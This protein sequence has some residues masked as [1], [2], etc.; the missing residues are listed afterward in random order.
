M[1]MISSIRVNFIDIAY[2]MNVHVFI[3][4]EFI[5]RYGYER[6]VRK[7]KYGRG[8]VS[9]VACRKWIHK[10]YEYTREQGFSYKQDVN[11]GLYIFRDEKRLVEEKRNEQ[12]VRREYSVDKQG[13]II[14]TTYLGEDEDTGQV[15]RW[16]N[17][18]QGWKYVKTILFINK[19]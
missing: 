19:K 5:R 8:D 9:A 13:N 14:R 4:W 10:L 17:S 16:D 12:D 3:I 18:F 1:T 15:Y 6:G 7:D 2:S 11:K